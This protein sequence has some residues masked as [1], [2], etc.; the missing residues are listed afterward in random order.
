MRRIVICVVLGVAFAAVARADEPADQLNR[1]LGQHEQKVDELRRSFEESVR[2]E[3]NALADKLFDLAQKNAQSQAAFQALMYVAI[4]VPDPELKRKA[5]AAL[6]DGHAKNERLSDLFPTLA[7][8]G[9]DAGDAILRKALADNPNRAV[10]GRAA[11]TLGALALAR[12]E[13]APQPEE[14][15]KDVRDAETNLQLAL[16][17][18]GDVPD[19]DATIGDAARESL[20][21]LK[22]LLSLSVGKAA[23]ET[24]ATVEGKKVKLSDYRGKVVVLKFGAT[25]CGPC[26]AMK[27]Q[28]EAL[29]KRYGDKPFAVVDVD[30]DE[31]EPAARQW[32]VRYL[33][34]V[35]V[36][37]GK[38]VIR[39]KGVREK[40]LDD[41]VEVLV[42]EAGK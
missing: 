4:D 17:K 5:I 27:P 40:D 30:V 33:P 32:A 18:Y 7:E 42:K 6:A 16:D 11:F 41:A 31:N 25:W 20:A 26:R 21:L 24:S 22:G 8:L 9:G 23:P 14:A 35:F 10:Q 29:A 34:A 19:G 12:V 2:K 13:A 37:D 3:Q 38:G 28:L 15:R 39:Y 1:L 36:L